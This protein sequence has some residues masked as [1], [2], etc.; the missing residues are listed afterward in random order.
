MELMYPPALSRYLIR[1]QNCS[2]FP[3]ASMTILSTRS[4][5][6]GS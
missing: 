4:G 5:Y 6:A 3:M 2:R 1:A